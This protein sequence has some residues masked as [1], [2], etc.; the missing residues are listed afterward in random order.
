M[1]SSS[2]DFEDKMTTFSLNRSWSIEKINFYRYK[3]RDNEPLKSP[4]FYA[5]E[6][7][8]QF[9][10]L[11]YPNG[12]GQPYDLR[13]VYLDASVQVKTISGESGEDQT[14]KNCYWKGGAQIGIDYT[15]EI[16][17]NNGNQP[18]TYSKFV[19]T[20]FYLQSSAF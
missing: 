1:A 3:P 13:K 17:L 15:I 4:V 20:I 12:S 16:W 19:K 18:M 6:H 7:D 11:I 14:S 8:L 5:P 10:I 9:T 2:F